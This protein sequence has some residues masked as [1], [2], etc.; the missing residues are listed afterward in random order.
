[1]RN[2]QF[3]HCFSLPVLLLGLVVS[4]CSTQ[5]Q[6]IKPTITLESVTPSANGDFCM[7]G[8]NPWMGGIATRSYANQQSIGKCLHPKLD[9][10]NAIVLLFGDDTGQAPEDYLNEELEFS[11]NPDL[12]F[13]AKELAELDCLPGSE[14]E[15]N[16]NLMKRGV[17]VHFAPDSH[18]PLD[19]SELQMLERFAKVAQGR[20]VV[21]LSAGHTD[22]TASEKHNQRLSSKRADS[23]KE[24]LVGYGLSTADVSVAAFASSKPVM[25]NDST[26]G[27]AANRRV[28][29]TVANTADKT[30]VFCLPETKSCGD[31]VF[32]G[33]K[34]PT[35]EFEACPAKE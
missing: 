35:C 31:G 28:E 2:I 13:T 14:C 1:M 9:L 10:D 34:A 30:G 32:V 8:T 5:P 16:L 3:T 25:P 22:S 11:L 33:R 26:A 18:N 23:V 27:K 17:V 7:A 24:L 15:S 20:R 29:V 19:Q 21:I 12:F 6:A 4:G